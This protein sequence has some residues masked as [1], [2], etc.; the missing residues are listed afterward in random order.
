MNTIRPS[1][2]A[3]CRSRISIAATENVIVPNEASRK[4]AVPG[5]VASIGD[6]KLLTAAEAGIPETLR[7]ADKN[8]F[9]PRF[10]FAYR[11]FNNNKTVIR[12]GFG[13]Y[14]VTILGSVLY[15]LIGIHTADVRAFTNGFAGGHPFFQWPDVKATAELIS[16]V[17]TADF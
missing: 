12:G 13:V 3:L 15:S 11:P 9:A 14:T 17:G 7:F 5:F 16:P 6:T 10:G 4:L 2:T 1:T 8:N